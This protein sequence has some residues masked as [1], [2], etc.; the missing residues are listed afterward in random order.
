MNDCIFIM[1]HSVIPTHGVFFMLT[2][3][4]VFMLLNVHR[5]LSL[6]VQTENL[7]LVLILHIMVR[8]R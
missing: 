3:G 6:H 5:K 8:W 1:F 7:S 2:H 4:C